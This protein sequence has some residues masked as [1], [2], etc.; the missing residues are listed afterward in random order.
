MVDRVRDHTTVCVSN[1]AG[2]P[3]AQTGYPT[4]LDGP[5]CLPTWSERG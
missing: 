2:R 1:P 4:L 3:G 5:T